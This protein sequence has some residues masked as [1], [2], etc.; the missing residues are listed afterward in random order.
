MDDSNSQQL[1]IFGQKKPPAIGF[2]DRRITFLILT[3]FNAL[4]TDKFT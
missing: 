3:Q 2:P 4:I 1:L